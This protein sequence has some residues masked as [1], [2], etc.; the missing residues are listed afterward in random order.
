MAV[1]ATYRLAMRALNR[2]LPI[3]EDDDM[4]ALD[5]L[6]FERHL[7]AQEPWSHRAATRIPTK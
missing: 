4:D 6:D 1:V 5:Y 3:P 2:F 7:Y